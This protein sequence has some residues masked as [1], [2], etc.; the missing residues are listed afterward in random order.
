MSG[1]LRYNCPMSDNLSIYFLRHGQTAFSRANAF[2]G[3]GLN[4]ELTADGSEMARC[5]A[6]KYAQTAWQAV[7]CSP[8]L[9]A[10]QTAQPLCDRI[11]L[12]PQ[13]RDGLKEICYGA[14]EG[15]SVEEVTRD[16]HDDYLRWTADPAWNAPSSAPQNINAKNANSQFLNVDGA[17]A[18]S[19]NANGENVKGANARLENASGESLPSENAI[20]IARRASQ[21]VEEIRETHASGNVLV[22]SHKA[23]IRIVLCSLLGVDL[24]RFRFRFDCPTASLCVVEF[25]RNGPMLRA[26]ADRR[27][28]NERLIALP[29]T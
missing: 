8:L 11:G 27:H 24:G 17:N 7:Y 28:L 16:Y 19:A 9:R 26:L 20:A 3:A 1:Q 12:V 25:Q 22:V 6:E 18:N 10:R 21:V 5:F 23:T 13:T 29:G 15:L 2:C 14:W 4:P